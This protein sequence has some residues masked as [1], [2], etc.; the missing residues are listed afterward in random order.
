MIMEDDDL[1]VMN[2]LRKCV[3]DRYFFVMNE[4]NNT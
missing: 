2:R 4:I 1:N 3:V